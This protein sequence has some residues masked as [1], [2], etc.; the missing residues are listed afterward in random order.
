MPSR[1]SRRFFSAVLPSTTITS[2]WATAI[3]RSRNGLHVAASSGIG[4]RFCGGGGGGRLGVTKHFGFFSLGSL[5][6]V[7]GGGGGGAQGGGGGGC[8]VARGVPCANAP[9][10]RGSSR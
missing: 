7:C 6:F 2:G 10:S 3:S 9:G 5:C 8:C 1:V 4:A